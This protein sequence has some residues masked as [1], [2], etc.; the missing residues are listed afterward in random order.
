MEHPRALASVLNTVEATGGLPDC[1]RTKRQAASAGWER[2]E[3]V[4][5][6]LPGMSIGGNTFGNREGLLPAIGPHQRYVEADLDDDGGRRGAHRLVFLDGARGAN[7]RA[8]VTVD[9]YQSF[10]QVLPR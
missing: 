1:Y 5:E 9:H 4:W 7:A 8:W 6:D 10:V 2:G 3:P